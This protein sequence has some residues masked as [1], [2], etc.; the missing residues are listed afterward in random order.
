MALAAP[1]N[2]HNSKQPSIQSTVM[3]LR[4]MVFAECYDVSKQSAQALVNMA[5]TGALF[6]PDTPRQALEECVSH[7]LLSQ[8]NH[9]F[10]LGVT[11]VNH[12]KCHKYDQL[13]ALVHSNPIILK[14]IQA[15]KGCRDQFGVA[16][17]AAFQSNRVL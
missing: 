2:S 10:C 15:T 11:L 8:D 17:E 4:D 6:A 14:R 3:S 7:L 13:C 5:S 16:Q 9:L 12:A 1:V